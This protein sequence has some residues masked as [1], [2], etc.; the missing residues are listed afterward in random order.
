MRRRTRGRGIKHNLSVK[1]KKLLW[2][3]NLDDFQ[4]YPSTS[5]FFPWSF[6]HTLRRQASF[7]PDLHPE[8]LCPLLILPRGDI[9]LM[10]SLRGTSHTHCR[11]IWVYKQLLSHKALPSLSFAHKREKIRKGVKMC[12]FV[13]EH[14]IIHFP[15]KLLFL[16]LFLHK[17]CLSKFSELLIVECCINHSAIQHLD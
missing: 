17:L 15:N 2:G 14:L 16:I 10:F 9:T 13:S 8:K 5:F 1:E 3:V 6:L 7:V 12:I 4:L 11:G